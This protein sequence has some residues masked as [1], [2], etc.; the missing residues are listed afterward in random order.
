[1]IGKFLLAGF[2]AI[3]VGASKAGLKGIGIVAVVLVAMAYGARDSTGILLPL[4]IAGDILAVIYYKRHCRW[5]YLKKFL[6][7]MVVGV[8]IAVLAGKDLPEEKFKI[9]MGAIILIS[10]VIM[11][12]WDY[13]G[14][15]TFPDNWAFVGSAGVAAGF[16]TM[17][18]NL[19]GAFANMF[20][21]ATRIPKNEI[22]GTSAWLFFIINVFKFPF[23]Y[24]VWGTISPQTL[25]TD[26]Q[27]IPFI[28][29]GFFLGMKIVAYINELQYRYFLLIVTAIGA[30]IVLI[31]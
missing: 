15:K 1:M 5:I 9:W 27:Y 24:W 4:L 2:A 21:L 30:I 29:L 12:W 26:L 3:L 13:H 16:T 19:A 11:F 20:F 14:R 18:G 8:L 6:P 23:H 25:L 7:A 28:F 10:V 31:R 17:I 22:I